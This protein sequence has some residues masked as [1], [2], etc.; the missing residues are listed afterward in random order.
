MWHKLVEKGFDKY[1]WDVPRVDTPS[2]VAPTICKNVLQ[3][4][5]EALVEA[6]FAFST[7]KYHPGKPA[8]RD[9]LASA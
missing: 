5:P 2:T 4:T 1:V 9:N 6:A 3:L 7:T 8:V